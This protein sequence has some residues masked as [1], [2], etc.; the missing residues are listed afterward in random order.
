M[1]GEVKLLLCTAGILKDPKRWATDVYVCLEHEHPGLI[2]I[3]AGWTI[4]NVVLDS[5]VAQLTFSD[6]ISAP[7]KSP[8]L[9]HPTTQGR[10]CMYSNRWPSNHL[11]SGLKIDPHLSSSTLCNELPLLA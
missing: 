6:S 9:C 3:V 10:D 5:V 2:V 7:L 1:V 4:Q 8:A 11:H